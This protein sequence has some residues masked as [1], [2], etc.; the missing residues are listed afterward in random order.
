M[1]GK[2]GTACKDLSVLLTW[3]VTVLRLMLSFQSFPSRRPGP[4]SFRAPEAA[5]P[6][7]IASSPAR[8]RP[9]PRRRLVTGRP[10]AGWDPA[11]GR[12]GSE[13][14]ARASAAPRA[15]AGAVG[16]VLP[17]RSEK[18]ATRISRRLSELGVV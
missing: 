6:P 13:R 4:G 8:G 14:E 11:R 12:P 18:A 2:R 10:A 9:S 17:E 7:A 16:R 15:W 3:V 1:E 5:R